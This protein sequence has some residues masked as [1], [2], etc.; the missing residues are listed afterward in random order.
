MYSQLTLGRLGSC[1]E[2]TRHS[3]TELCLELHRKRITQLEPCRKVISQRIAQAHHSPGQ[4]GKDVAFCLR[5]IQE[6]GVANSHG[7][8]RSFGHSHVQLRLSTSSPL[9]AREHAHYELITSEQQ[10]PKCVIYIGHHADMETQ[11]EN[12]EMRKMKAGNG[13]W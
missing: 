4:L 6:H 10:P 9:R 12:A 8:R 11:G 7:L 5:S 1:W 13:K 2:S 3:A